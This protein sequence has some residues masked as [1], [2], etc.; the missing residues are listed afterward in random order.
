MSPA[1]G[2]PAGR[3]LEVGVDMVQPAPPSRACRY[4]HEKLVAKSQA[5]GAG[6]AGCRSSYTP[7]VGCTPETLLLLLIIYFR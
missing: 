1:L 6:V 2:C 4:Q 5:W 7:K 3:F